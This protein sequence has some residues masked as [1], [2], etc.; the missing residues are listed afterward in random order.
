MRKVIYFEELEK[1]EIEYMK[2]N[3]RWKLERELLDSFQKKDLKSFIDVAYKEYMK[4]SLPYKYILDTKKFRE[5]YEKLWEIGKYLQQQYSYHFEWGKELEMHKNFL[6]KLKANY[7]E[8]YISQWRYQREKFDV[9]SLSI[10]EVISKYISLPKNLRR[11][12]RCPLHSDKTASFRVYPDTQSFYC[13]WCH[14]G[15]NA[16]NFVSEIENISLKEA[17]KKLSNLYTK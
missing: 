3:T 9:A 12:I 8:K 4:I 1:I 11:N 7:K 16:V 14:K 17:F 13:F 15:W 2:K 10:E 5:G 6:D